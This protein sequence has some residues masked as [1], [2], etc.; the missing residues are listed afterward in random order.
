MKVYSKV[1]VGLTYQNFGSAWLGILRGSTENI[2]LVFNGLYNLCATSGE[3]Q[4][5]DHLQCVAIF[6]SD[7]KGMRRFFFNQYY[8]PRYISSRDPANGKTVR[9][10]MRYA[11]NQLRELSA[12]SHESFLDF[13]RRYVPDV[14]HTGQITA[15]RPDNDLKDLIVMNAFKDRDTAQKSVDID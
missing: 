7:Y 15:E 11:L 9:E 12:T 5:Q 13:T 14:Y 1:D 2:E 8:L 10:S 3:L 4:Y 6:W